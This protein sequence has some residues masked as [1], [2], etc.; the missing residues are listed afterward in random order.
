MNKFSHSLFTTIDNREI[1]TG[2]YIEIIRVEN[3]RTRG[4]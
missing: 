2:Y 4:G 1:T 3:M